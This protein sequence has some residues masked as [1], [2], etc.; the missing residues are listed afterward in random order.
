MKDRIREI[1]GV[2]LGK[3][4]GSG[5]GLILGWIIV[6][7]GVIKGLFV[8]VCVAAGFYIGA[9]YDASENNLGGGYF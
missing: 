6:R 4:V 2:H 1:L 5:F 9:R 3:I 8:A 7:Y